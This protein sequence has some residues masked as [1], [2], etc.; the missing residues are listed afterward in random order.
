MNDRD[1]N[2]TR[3]QRSILERMVR[4]STT[5]TEPLR[6]RKTASFVLIPGH[7]GIE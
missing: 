3:A 5:T 2:T 7:Y 1:R 4:V 6:R